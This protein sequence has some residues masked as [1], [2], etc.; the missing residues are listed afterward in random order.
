VQ[1]IDFAGH[2]QLSRQIT[3]ALHGQDGRLE[4]RTAFVP[5]GRGLRYTETGQ[6]TLIS[7]AV[8]QATRS[9][10]W[11]A[12]NTGVV[13]RFDTGAPFHRFD[14]TGT[15]QGTSHLCGAD[16]Y[17]VTYDF[18]QWPAWTATWRVTGPRKNYTSISQY[19]PDL[20]LG[21]P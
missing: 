3:D 4:G 15:T 20:H 21:C 13:V 5:N 14:L 10:L 16:M 9:Y 12:D 17:L 6:L 11:D 18:T 1:F 2:W 8:M 19:T 7:G